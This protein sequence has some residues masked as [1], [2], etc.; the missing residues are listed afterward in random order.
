ME[1]LCRYPW[2]GNIRELENVIQRAVLLAKKPIIDIELLPASL[3]S[4]SSSVCLGGTASGTNT[5]PS[6]AA[7]NGLPPP[8]RSIH[9]RLLTLD[10]AL[11]EPERR[12][13]VEA[14]KARNWNRNET[15]LALGINRTTL[16]KK[17]KRLGIEALIPG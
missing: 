12:I 8:S 6:L 16:Y 17:I 13:I 11:E 2:P 3:R 15:A 1:L 4:P 7:G 9:D 14:L 5:S 10:E